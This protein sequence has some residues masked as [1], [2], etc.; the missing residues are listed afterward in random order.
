[1]AF[2]ALCTVM[3]ERTHIDREHRAGRDRLRAAWAS[4]VTISAP[5]PTDV[6]HVATSFRDAPP[7]PLSSMD[8]VLAADAITA[9]FLSTAPAFGGAAPES[10]GTL[11]GSPGIGMGSGGDGGGGSAATSASASPPTSGRHVSISPAVADAEAESD[12]HA[13]DPSPPDLA[14]TD[15]DPT[16]T[17]HNH[18]HGDADHDADGSTLRP[19]TTIGEAETMDVHEDGPGNGRPGGGG[20]DGVRTDDASSRSASASAGAYGDG[21]GIEGRGEGGQDEDAASDAAGLADTPAP[22]AVGDSRGAAAVDEGEDADE[23]FEGMPLENEPEYLEL[24]GEGGKEAAEDRKGETTGEGVEA[25]GGPFTQDT[26]TTPDGIQEGTTQEASSSSDAASA[27]EVEVVDGGVVDANATDDSNG[28]EVEPDVSVANESEEVSI[29]NASPTPDGIQEGT[30]QEA[31]SSSDAAS[32]AGVEVVDGGVVDANATDD[33]NGVEFEPDVSVANESEE[34]SPSSPPP[35]GAPLDPPAPTEPP[36]SP[37]SLPPP[38]PPLS[39]SPPPPLSP[40]PTFLDAEAGAAMEAHLMAMLTSP[41]PVALASA[42]THPYDPEDRPVWPLP[43]EM[44]RSSRCLPM[45]SSRVFVRVKDAG[46][47]GTAAAGGVS[48]PLV[49]RVLLGRDASPL[50]VPERAAVKVVLTLVRAKDED[51][52]GDEDSKSDRDGGGDEEGDEDGD[53]DG[54]EEG[55]GDEEH[56]SG[57]AKTRRK[58][59]AGSKRAAQERA[60]NVASYEK[61]MTALD[62][63]NDVTGITPRRKQGYE[64]SVKIAPD[65]AVVEVKVVAHVRE[66]IVWALQTLRQAMYEPPKAAKN[67]DLNIPVGSTWAGHTCAPTSLEVK[68][69]PATDYRG[70]LVDSVR[71]VLPVN[72]IKHVIEIMSSLKYTH[73]HWHLTDDQGFALTL[74]A[75]RQHAATARYT[76]GEVSTI[77]RHAAAYGV[78][79]VPEIDIPGHA[80]S[81]T[82]HT[83]RCTHTA[84]EDSGK[85]RRHASLQGRSAFGHPLDVSK[86]ATDAHVIKILSEVRAMFPGRLLH[87]GGR[88]VGTFCL[89]ES[90]ALALPPV[91]TRAATARAAAWGNTDPHAHAAASR[92]SKRPRPGGGPAVMS[93]I[94]LPRGTL[95]NTTTEEPTEE[96]SPDDCDADVTMGG[97]RDREAYILCL[98]RDVRKAEH[99]L[100]MSENGADDPDIR[101]KRALFAVHG[102]HLRTEL[103]LLR[104]GIPARDI[105]RW[106]GVLDNVGGGG[107]VPP[108]DTLIIALESVGAGPGGHHIALTQGYRSVLGAGWEFNSGGFPDGCATWMDCYTNSPFSRFEGKRAVRFPDEDRLGR[109][110][111]GQ[112]A[113]WELHPVDYHRKVW[114]RLAAVGER[115]WTDPAEQECRLSATRS[116]LSHVMAHIRHEHNA[117][118]TGPSVMERR[119]VVPPGYY[120]AMLAKLGPLPECQQEGGLGRPHRRLFYR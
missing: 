74:R 5:D 44:Q 67:D 86:P 90:G 20:G 40:P 97:P 92:R 62:R 3:V 108:E 37:P 87:L 15:R 68:D 78:R 99:A 39:P 116:R 1:M 17:D 96:S 72:F 7:Q 112:A 110:L 111:G 14:E 45:T 115:L 61:R 85:F 23:V 94:P 88:N 19:P 29:D 21:A 63:R 76:P 114:T 10:E 84:T 66:A 42:E 65:T 101:H 32:A 27:A 9:S 41:P 51:I 54:D 107:Y 18:D 89:A 16:R 53:E 8:A 100:A 98:H 91:L 30:T 95:V 102:F 31:S 38:S 113:A 64:L 34:A 46:G 50:T 75:A 117:T 79:V 2:M 80:Y 22:R 36:P 59:P 33:G 58:P 120:Q 70:F 60:R 119:E 49:R 6:R 35:P 118:A 82:G 13:S 69:A 25:P 57:D 104:L 77:L 55:D 26:F 56:S 109:V 73:L 81:W 52:G 106:D 93:D 28:A 103:A 48:A 71:F 47:F 43:R 11:A 83:I 105:V 24:G 12:G 4:H